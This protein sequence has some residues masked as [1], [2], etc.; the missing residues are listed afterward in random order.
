MSYAQTV[1]SSLF[2]QKPFILSAEPGLWILST[3]DS[4][5]TTCIVFSS[6]TVP[7]VYMASGVSYWYAS[8]SRDW[9]VVNWANCLGTQP[10]LPALPWAGGVPTF[11]ELVTYLHT[12]RIPGPCEG[13][14]SSMDT[15]IYN[16]DGALT[17]IGG[18]TRHLDVAGNTLQFQDTVGG[19]QFNINLPLLEVD[20]PIARFNVTQ[21]IATIGNNPALSDLVVFDQATGRFWYRDA[22]SFLPT[23]MQPTQ[24]GIAYGNQG[25]QTENHLG[26]ENQVPVGSRSNAIGSYLPPTMTLDES[27]VIVAYQNLSTAVNSYTHS[28]IIIS[29]NSSEMLSARNSHILAHEL[30]AGGV[31]MDNCIYI[32]NMRNVVPANESM[33]FNNDEFGNPIQMAKESYYF[34][35]GKNAVVMN[36]GELVFDFGDRVRWFG[37]GG[38]TQTQMLYYEPSTGDFTYGPIPS[39]SSSNAIFSVQVQPGMV[40]PTGNNQIP[41]SGTQLQVNVI[42]GKYDYS[43]GGLNIITGTYTPSVTAECEITASLNM[44]SV[45]GGQFILYFRNDTDSVTLYESNFVLAASLNTGI[46]YQHRA[47]LAAGKNYSLRIVNSSGSTATVLQGNYSINKI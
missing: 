38:G 39:S 7:T 21:F 27:N 2:M 29:G 47:I 12:N 31:D 34:G 19:G 46:N 16:T 41:T 40:V 20:C 14:G 4:V 3:T 36:N 45:P 25:T 37:V 30:Q 11:T 8:A 17:L 28:N 1:L 24:L 33:C 5:G 23:Q 42:R 9:S 44:N 10:P 43:G 32:G 13:G 26:Y 6:C 15:N 22:N 35:S 18:G